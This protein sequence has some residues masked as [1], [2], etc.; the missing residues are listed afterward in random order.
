MHVTRTSAEL[1]DFAR[2]NARDR[3]R[4]RARDVQEYY[5][6]SMAD[7][8]G[9]EAML[10]KDR[11]VPTQSLFDAFA[12]H[13][14]PAPPRIAFDFV[15]PAL[16][17][18]PSG[19]MRCCEQESGPPSNIPRAATAGSRF[20]GTTLSMSGTGL[21]CSATRY[22]VLDWYWP[23]VW[24]YAL[25]VPWSVLTQRMALYGVM[26]KP[27][28]TQRMVLPASFVRRKSS[29]DAGQGTLSAYALATR[30]PFPGPNCT[31]FPGPNCTEFPGPNCTETVVGCIC[32]QAGRG[33]VKTSWTVSAYAMVLR[34]R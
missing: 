3:A 30:C 17:S 11:Q 29:I 21:A 16:V 23:C 1:R 25:G 24:G 18:V 14:V 27:V 26:L 15:R 33:Q 7:T 28:L 34:A 5:A 2:T 6:A 10:C 12:P 19:A 4:D 20:A 13:F 9:E 32:C 22:L 8:S 31:E